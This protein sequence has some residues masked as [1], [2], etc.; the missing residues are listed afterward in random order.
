[1]SVFELADFLGTSLLRISKHA[2]HK[3]H[4]DFHKKK[5]GDKKTILLRKE[6]PP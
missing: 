4:R 2:F 5:E 1:M 3:K 6:T